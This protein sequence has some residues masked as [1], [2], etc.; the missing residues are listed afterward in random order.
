MINVIIQIIAMIMMVVSVDIKDPKFLIF[1]GFV[2]VW[3][4]IRENTSKHNDE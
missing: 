3:A 1:H 2:L 4:A